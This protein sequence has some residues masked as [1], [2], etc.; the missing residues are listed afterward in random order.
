VRQDAFAAQPSIERI[1][2]RHNRISTVEGGA[3]VG[4]KSPKEIYLS[5]NHL[6]HLNSDVFQVITYINWLIR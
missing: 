4:L 6:A 3:F 2:L 5:G 1:D